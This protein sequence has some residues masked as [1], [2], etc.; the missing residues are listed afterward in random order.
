MIRNASPDPDFAECRHIIRVP[1]NARTLSI[2]LQLCSPMGELNLP[3]FSLEDTYQAFTAA[4]RYEMSGAQE[5]GRRRLFQS[6]NTDLLV[7][8][9]IAAQNG[10]WNEARMAAITAIRHSSSFNQHVPLLESTDSHIYHSFLKFRHSYLSTFAGTIPSTPAAFNWWPSSAQIH[11]FWADG[12]EPSTASSE[13]ILF[14]TM[15]NCQRGRTNTSWATV[16]EYHK[17]LETI[18]SAL[19]EVGSLFLVI[20]ISDVIPN[21]IL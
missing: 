2:L 3:S 18:Q 5:F 17:S 1:D 12:L 8:Y 11:R 4:V 7:V 6:V 20:V 9:F 16:A 10:W 15:L 13:A 21:L 19:S 14:L